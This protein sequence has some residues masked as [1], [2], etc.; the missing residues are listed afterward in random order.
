ME[1]QGFEGDP[2]LLRFVQSL[3]LAQFDTA[4]A[5]KGIEAAFAEQD[6][7]LSEQIGLAQEQLNTAQ[8]QLRNQE[9][10][11]AALTQ[12][13]VSLDEFNKGL[14]LGNLSTLSPASRLAEARAQFEDL[15]SQALSGNL[16]AAGGLPAA[17]RAFLEASR[18]FNAS[19]RG[20]VGDFN[21]VRD[22]LAIV[23]SGLEAELTVEE[24]QLVVLQTQA[25]SLAAQVLILESAREAARL[26]AERQI[27]EIQEAAQKAAED[28]QRQLE[29]FIRTNN[30][31]SNVF[32]ELTDQG[33]TIVDPGIFASAQQSTAASLE[34]IALDTSATVDVLA[35]GLA[36]LDRRLGAVETAV[37]TS[38]DAIRRGF[39][40]TEPVR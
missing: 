29:E 3:E 40:E 4:E 13:I 28:A 12:V 9:Q 36:N 30:L 2:A 31:L 1:R 10:T 26:D 19:G 25:D 7:N 8:E 23:G 16:D 33:D 27:R 20:F 24:Q 35:V 21:L 37:N 39:E 34:S 5:L 17:A 18:A 15:R 38:T 22:S 14:L 32:T 6:A 11:V